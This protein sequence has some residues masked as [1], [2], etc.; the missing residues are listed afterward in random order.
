LVI[1][2][3][4]EDHTPGTVKPFQVSLV[5]P[6]AYPLSYAANGVSPGEFVALTGLNLGSAGS[7]TISNGLLPT[8]LGGATVTFN[9]APAPLVYVSNT[10]IN[11][12]VPYEIAGQNSA[13]VTVKVG[14][15]EQSATVPV[16]PAVPALFTTNSSGTGQASALNQDFSVNSPSN[17]ANPGDIIVLYGTGEGLETPTPEDGSITPS[18]TATPAVPNSQLF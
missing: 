17:S 8:T 14:G 10:Q 12:I 18:T 7:P 9:G 5:E 4:E 13:T 15:V 11:A 16:L 3:L 2:P 6:V 1:K